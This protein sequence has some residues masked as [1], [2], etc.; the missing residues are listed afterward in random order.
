MSDFKKQFESWGEYQTF[1]QKLGQEYEIEHKGTCEVRMFGDEK[2]C[3]CE[4]EYG[5]T[6]N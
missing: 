1:L 6:N 5:D 4:E 3:T 2:K